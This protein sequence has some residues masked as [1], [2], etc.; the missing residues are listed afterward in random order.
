MAYI[1]AKIKVTRHLHLQRETNRR[2]SNNCVIRRLSTKVP[3][4]KWS[5]K[6]GFIQ[7]WLR[8]LPCLSIV[9]QAVINTLCLGGN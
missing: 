3:P 6:H 1:K 2:H 4:D 7:Q 9:R 5:K 8:D